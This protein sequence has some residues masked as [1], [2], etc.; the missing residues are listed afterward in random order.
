ME[1]EKGMPEDKCII[2]HAS[3]GSDTH[4]VCPKT[5]ESWLSLLEASKV[6]NHTAVLEV[7]QSL[8][9]K[10]IPKI[11]YHRKCW[12]LFTMK[13]H[14]DTLKQK[15]CT[16]CANDDPQTSS[17]LSKR[18]VRSSTESRVYEPIC[19]FCNTDKFLKVSKSREKLVKA[20]ELRA[21]QRLRECAMQKRDEKI[22]A[23]T[24]R[25]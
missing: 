22:L 12:S 5:Y 15:A 7:A 21:D 6:R 2:H 25:V 1:K 14:L 10:E 13:R 4:L 18:P 11:Y 9:E 19:I 8:G 23:V 24:S 17:T 20:V 3:S 16:C